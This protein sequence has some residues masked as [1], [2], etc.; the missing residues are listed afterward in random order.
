MS[1]TAVST[2]PA[3]RL[4]VYKSL[5]DVP[6]RYRLRNH[7]ATYDARDVWDEF[8]TDHLFQ[9]YNSERFKEDAIRAGRY[10]K[11]HMDARGRHHALATPADVEAWMSDLLDRVKVKTAYNSY[12]VRVERFYSWLQW[13]T[14]HPHVYNPVLMAAADGDASQTV[15]DEKMARRRGGSKR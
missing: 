15:W 11:E 8:L 3:E 1:Q 4:G 5:D 12:W 9:T 10:W 2:D 6:D 14:E 7:T 13:H